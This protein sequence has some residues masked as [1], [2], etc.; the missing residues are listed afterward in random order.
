MV[1]Q[2]L[3]LN[4]DPLLL[5]RHSPRDHNDRLC[6]RQNT[7]VLL[8]L[9]STHLTHMLEEI[10]HLYLLVSCSYL[11][12]FKVGVAVKWRVKCYVKYQR[13]GERKLSLLISI[14]IYFSVDQRSREIWNLICALCSVTF[15]GWLFV[16]P[17][18]IARLAP[19]NMEFSCQEYW[20]G[21]PFPSPIWY[22]HIFNI[23]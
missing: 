3:E 14:S 4:G 7:W 9:H 19:L 22:I 20:S 15:R 2:N 5:P 23:Y 16:T 6:Y 21:L 18:P 11:F 10:F 1:T 17:W 8:W 12:I 13:G